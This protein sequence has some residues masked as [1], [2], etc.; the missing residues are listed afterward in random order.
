MPLFDNT[1]LGVAERVQSP[2]KSIPFE[3]M[4]SMD[5]GNSKRPH[6]PGGVEDQIASL[7]LFNSPRTRFRV[8]TEDSSSLNDRSVSA[9]FGASANACKIQIPTVWLGKLNST[10]SWASQFLANQNPQVLAGRPPP[11]TSI[12]ISSAV[13]TPTCSPMAGRFAGWGDGTPSGASP[14]GP[15]WGPRWLPP[16]NPSACCTFCVVSPGP[17][18]TPKLQQLQDGRSAPCHRCAWQH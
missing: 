10:H 5:V 14:R 7:R 17:I 8:E 13:S 1:Q 9:D 15:G 4:D 12:D 16:P 11:K 3:P 2:N 6:S 18:N